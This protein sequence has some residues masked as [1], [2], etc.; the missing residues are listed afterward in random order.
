MMGV[1]DFMIVLSSTI[2]ETVFVYE[3]LRPVQHSLT[4]TEVSCSSCASQAALTS[5]G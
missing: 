2:G 3:N 5:R 4:C 1:K